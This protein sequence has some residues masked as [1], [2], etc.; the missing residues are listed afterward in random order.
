ML[1]QYAAMNVECVS[2]PSCHGACNSLR[3]LLVVRAVLLQMRPAKLHQ[4]YVVTTTVVC[5]ACAVSLSVLLVT[6]DLINVSKF[7]DRRSKVRNFLKGFRPTDRK[8]WA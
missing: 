3:S 4:A 2:H 7:A 1:A 8:L 6:P 5:L